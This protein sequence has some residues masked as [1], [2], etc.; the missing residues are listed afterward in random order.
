[1][2]QL[3]FEYDDSL[4]CEVADYRGLVIRAERDE[5][6][7]NPFTDWDCEPPTLVVS[8][9]HNSL[10]DYSGGEL[11]SPL[12]LISDGKL[13][14]SRYWKAAAQALDLCPSAFRAECAEEARD[15]SCS[16]VTVV[17]EKLQ[18]AL[19]DARPSYYSGN[20]SDYLSALESLWELAGCAALHW[21]SQGYS[22]GHY[23]QGLSVATPAWVKKVGAPIESHARQLEGARKLWGAWAWGDVYAFVI[24][25][26]EGDIL[27]SCAGFYGNC[28]KESG[29]A[30]A[31]QEAADWILANAKA[32]RAE[33]V[34]AAIRNRIPLSY[35]PSILAQAGAL[36]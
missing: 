10:T 16:L 2:R 15:Y 11:E 18:E 25:N 32:R 4:G 22:Q 5:C 36:A 26:I 24:A 14:L 17:R 30:E 20:A 35:R 28:H 31:A 12:D 9:R 29:L 1:M 19:S 23:A 34:K 13:R 27:D 21:S 8:G 3:S 6:A 33:A 7:S